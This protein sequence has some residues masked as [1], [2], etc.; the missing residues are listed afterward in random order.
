MKKIFL[1]AA[2]ALSF[3]AQ[4]GGSSSYI[5]NDVGGKVAF[6]VYPRSKIYPDGRNVITADGEILVCPANMV[7]EN[8]K[9]LNRTVPY[10]GNK[11]EPL[12][13]VRMQDD[14]PTGFRVSAYEY[15][16]H[17]STGAYRVLIVYYSKFA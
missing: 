5:S 11:S 16:F 10:F 6:D 17:G 9:C 15:R 13:W 14:A 1:L 3:S 4:A 12:A 2:I 7:V 8:S